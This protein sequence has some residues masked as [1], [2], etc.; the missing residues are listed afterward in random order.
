[1]QKVGDNEDLD[2]LSAIGVDDD[3]EVEQK[4]KHSSVNQK[5]KKQHSA[6]PS[7]RLMNKLLHDQFAYDRKKTLFLSVNTVT[8]VAIQT[9]L[10]P[11][12]I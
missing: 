8:M 9:Q 4:S 5:H 6:V 10:D 7:H 3:E 12:Y 2:H 11:I 1:M